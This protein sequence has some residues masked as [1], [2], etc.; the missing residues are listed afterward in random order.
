MAHQ[1]G[2]LFRSNAGF[3]F[4]RLLSIAK[5]FD[6]VF[7]FVSSSIRLHTYF[8]ACIILLTESHTRESTRRTMK[9]YIIVHSVDIYK[10]SSVADAI[11]AIDSEDEIPETAESRYTVQF[12]TWNFSCNEILPSNSSF[13]A[14]TLSGFM[15]HKICGLHIAP[16]NK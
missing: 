7:F 3:E 15:H 4:V 6:V 12:C 10:N 14:R 13:V 8:N 11:E 5:N 1:I 9:C 16:I 2:V